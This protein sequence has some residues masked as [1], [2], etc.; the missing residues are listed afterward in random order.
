MPSNYNAIAIRYNQRPPCLLV[1]VCGVKSASAGSRL[2]ECLCMK[3]RCA[4]A[5]EG[6]ETEGSGLGQGGGYRLRTSQDT[7]QAQVFSGHDF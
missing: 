1:S 7:D 4:P 2:C 5:R 3:R 6:S